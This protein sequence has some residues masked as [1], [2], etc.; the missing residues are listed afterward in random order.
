MWRSYED[1]LRSQT[2]VYTWQ[3]MGSYCFLTANRSKTDDRICLI[4]HSFVSL[5]VLFTL[6]FIHSVYLPSVSQIFGGSRN[7]DRE[8]RDLLTRSTSTLSS[9]LI[10][11]LPMSALLVLALTFIVFDIQG[12]VGKEVIFFCLKILSHDS[13]QTSQVRA[14][15][16]V[17]LISTNIEII[18]GHSGSVRDIRGPSFGGTC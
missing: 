4:I 13:L 8:S 11:I 12:T 2:N 14:Y 16:K 1:R 17:G 10:P 7:F 9:R 6:H 3:D 18:G 5:V 15:S